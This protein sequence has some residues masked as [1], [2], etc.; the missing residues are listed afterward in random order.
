[1]LC[2]YANFTSADRTNVKRG[3]RYSQ[4]A[5][6]LTKCRRISIDCT[7]SRISSPAWEVRVS[8]APDFR[9]HYSLGL[10]SLP[11]C[12]LGYP[13]WLRTDPSKNPFSQ[14]HINSTNR[15]PSPKVFAELFSKSDR[16]PRTSN[17]HKL[18]QAGKNKYNHSF[19][20][21]I[22]EREL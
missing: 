2:V 1:M 15:L 8:A 7:I 13:I 21:K 6:K 3:R 16:I 14:T 22:K 5:R 4:A 17:P 20:C 11:L 19:Y 18:P 12:R 9:L 10:G